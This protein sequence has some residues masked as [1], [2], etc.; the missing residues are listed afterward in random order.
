MIEYTVQVSTDKTEWYLN[1][2]LHRTHGPAVECTDGDKVWYLNG[3]LHREDGPAI[4]CISGDK[5]WFLNG[6]QVTEAEVIK[7]VKQLTVAE[8][9]VLLG[10]KIKIIAG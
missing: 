2:Q 10:H 9:E 6:N 8:I 1:G 5:S 4:E 7:P 3:L